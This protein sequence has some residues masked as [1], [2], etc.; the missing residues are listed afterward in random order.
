[1]QAFNLLNHPQFVPGYVGDIASNG[2]TG[3]ARNFFIP[4]SGIFNNASQNFSSHPRLLQLALKF[5][6]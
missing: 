6:F 1:M 3:P 2:V 5:N 4:N